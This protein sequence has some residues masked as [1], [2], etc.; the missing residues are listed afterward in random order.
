MKPVKRNGCALPFHHLQVLSW[1]IVSLLSA[2]FYSLVVSSL[3]QS[4]WLALT[5][6]YSL[7]LSLSLVFGLLCTLHDP[8]DSAVRK[9]LEGKSN[10]GEFSSSLYPRLCTRCNTH[11]GALSKHCNKCNRCTESFDHHCDW[12]NNCVGAGNYRMFVLLLC[13]LEMW[14]GLELVTVVYVLMGIFVDE[15]PGKSLVMRFEV[16][17]GGYCYIVAMLTIAVLCILIVIGNGYLILF[18]GWLR[19]KGLST[20]DFIMERRKR[21]SQVEPS[22]DA[23]FSQ[24]KS[25]NSSVLVELNMSGGEN[26]GE[27]TLEQRDHQDAT[28]SGASDFESRKMFSRTID[29]SSLP[30]CEKPTDMD[31]LPSNKRR[32]ARESIFSVEENSCDEDVIEPPQGP[33]RHRTG[34]L[35]LR[36]EFP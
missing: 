9:L 18:H 16:G 13:T 19:I 15:E 30:S 29:N 8:T 22:S 21:R 10:S 12:L 17:D 3:T 34:P 28:P 25:E 23:A 2:L 31:F 4:G 26:R 20:Y 27:H 36:T 5:A 24:R 1:C 33:G 14:T 32:R 35:P 7:S 11:V 6:L